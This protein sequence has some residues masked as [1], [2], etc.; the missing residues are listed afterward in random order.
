MK[1]V[2][3]NLGTLKSDKTEIPGFRGFDTGCKYRKMLVR[4]VRV[5]EE[6]VLQIRQLVGRPSCGILPRDSVPERILPFVVGPARREEMRQTD[7]LENSVTEGMVRH[8]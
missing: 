4:G 6:A 1:T 8:A 2:K 7:H 3:T 5:A